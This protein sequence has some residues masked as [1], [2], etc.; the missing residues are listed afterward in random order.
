MVEAGILSTAERSSLPQWLVRTL[1]SAAAG[2][3]VG[4]EGE[5][6]SEAGE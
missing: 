2:G 4:R 6:D 3:V 1:C 5:L